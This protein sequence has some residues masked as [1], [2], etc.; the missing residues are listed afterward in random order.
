MNASYVRD[1]NL[2]WAITLHK[3]RL[4]TTARKDNHANGNRSTPPTIISIRDEHAAGFF[5]DFAVLIFETNG[6]QEI[7]KILRLR[8]ENQTGLKHNGSMKLVEL[9]ANLV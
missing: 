2:Y 1:N 8:K 6:Q 9:Q 5:C 3:N 4:Y 7:L